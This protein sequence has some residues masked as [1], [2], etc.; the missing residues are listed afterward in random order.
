MSRDGLGTAFARIVD[1]RAGE[2][3][4]LARSAAALLFIVAAHAVLETA[5]DSLLL[6]ILPAHRLGAVYLVVALALVPVAALTARLAARVGSRRTLTMGL[7]LTVVALAGLFVARQSAASVVGTYVVSG[8]VSGLLIPLFWSLIAN[9]LTA[10]Q[11]RRLFGLIAAAGTVGSVAGSGVAFGLV[12]LIPVRGLLLVS[13]V[14]ALAASARLPKPSADAAADTVSDAVASRERPASLLSDPFVRRVALLIAASTATF[15]LLDFFFKWTVARSV[16]PERV[17]AFVARYYLLTSGAALVAQLA[18]S[19]ALLRRLGVA[20]TLLVAPA[21]TFVAAV[22]AAAFGGAVPTVLLLKATDGTLRGSVYRTSMELAYQPLAAPARSRVKPLVDG[23]LARAV[24][25]VVGGTLFAAGVAGHLSAGALAAVTLALA[26]VWLA[27]ARTIK[28]PYL[29]LLR[30]AIVRDQLTDVNAPDPLDL[31]NAEALIGYLS[32]PDEFLVL[33]AMNALARRGRAGLISGLM[34]LREEESV[35]IRALALFA[36]SDREDW[37]QWARKLLHDRR[38]TVRMAAARALA[39]HRKLDARDLAKDETPRVRAYAALYLT[40]KDDGADLATDSAVGKVLEREGPPGDA[41]RDGLVSAIA[42]APSSDRLRHLLDLLAGASGAPALGT[43]ELARAV[44]AQHAEAV[45]PELIVRLGRREAREAIRAALLGFGAGAL[46]RLG[47]VLRDPSRPR[48]LRI[49]IPSTVA[50]FGSKPAAQLLLETIEA[51]ADGLVRYKALRALGRLIAES[52]LKVDRVRVERLAE[53]NLLEYFRLL[54]LRAPLESTT[55]SASTSRRPADLTGRILLGMLKDKSR[56][57]LERVF[58]LL[59][60][61][62]PDEDIHRAHVAYW[63][64]D[65]RM[66]ANAVEFLAALLGKRDEAHL[67]E[68]LRIAGEDGSI[69]DVVER[70]RGLLPEQA[71]S[72]REEALRRLGSDEDATLAAL[73]ALHGAALAGKPGR[74]VIGSAERVPIEL[75]LSDDLGPRR[76][77]VDHG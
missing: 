77:A 69:D 38:D 39:A 21:V 25:A 27:V 46:D 34:L 76:A 8:L 3:R 7:G 53:R 71:P 40:L 48:V 4:P 13:A 66:R 14:L 72:S 60:I 9:V 28:K 17:P 73:A 15:V 2:A 30:R 24:Q 67:A 31:Q 62:Y 57:S 20:S 45:V 61:A 59:K 33:G 29:G 65:K 74:A 19:R 47:G 51:D 50:R 58:R 5:R 10:T 37:L 1:I 52:R 11:A 43:A 55:L 22:L 64:A 42:D 63:A 23:A 41:G 18:A 36:A 56:Q 68:L 6:S 26:G 49:H 32:H 12:G 75:S 35:V 70:S 44:S 54:G 16:R